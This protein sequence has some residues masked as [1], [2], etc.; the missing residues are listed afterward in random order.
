MLAAALAPQTDFKHAQ[1]EAVEGLMLQG[2]QLAAP[3]EHHF[4]PGV[5]AREIFMPAGSI[6]IGHEHRTEHLNIVLTGKARVFMGGEE[7]ETITAPAIFKSAAGVRKVLHVIE[8][9]RWMTIH[10]TPETDLDKLDAELIKPSE[11]FKNH[12]KNLPETGGRS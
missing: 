10:P 11:T 8:A 5:Y 12:M 2:P 1:I 7:L 6:V 4:A 9:M 3:V